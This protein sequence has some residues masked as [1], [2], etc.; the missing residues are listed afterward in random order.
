MICPAM[1]VMPTAAKLQAEDKVGDLKQIFL[2]WSKISYSLSLVVGV[3]LL[4]LGPEF[5]SWW[6]GP[7]LSEPAGKIIRVLMLSY[8]PFLPAR[9]VALPILMGL[10]KPVKPRGVGCT[11]TPRPSAKTSRTAG[12]ESTLSSSS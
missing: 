11:S 8:L 3:Y 2:K 1:V 7:S 4:V 10:G 5:V 9:G 6:V 12:W